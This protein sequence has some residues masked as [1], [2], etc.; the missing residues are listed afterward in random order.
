MDTN[1]L[2]FSL[3]KKLIPICETTLGSL[4]HTMLLFSNYWIFGASA[5]KFSISNNWGYL[6][7]N[8]GPCICL[9]MGF[10]ITEVAYVVVGILQKFPESALPED[11]K[12]DLYSCM[13][14]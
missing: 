9:G 8:E 7:F 1:Q 5:Q 13:A 11:E 6:P 10:A 12:V 2:S 4:H 3:L 14:A